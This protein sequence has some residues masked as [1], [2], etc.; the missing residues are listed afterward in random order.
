[1]LSVLPCVQ[2]AFLMTTPC[3]LTA[4]QIQI[5]ASS[6]GCQWQIIVTILENDRAQD[7]E[8]TV[9]AWSST[10]HFDCRCRSAHF[11]MSLLRRGHFLAMKS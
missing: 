5:F 9:N 6:R 4:D 2:M 3:R 8:G 7:K 11:V 10:L 1:M